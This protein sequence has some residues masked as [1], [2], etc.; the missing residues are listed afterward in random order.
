MLLAKRVNPLFSQALFMFSIALCACFSPAYGSADD[1][2]EISLDAAMLQYPDVGRDRIVFLFAND[3]WTVSRDGGLATPLASPAGR[4]LFP[5][6]STDCGTI[7]FVG[8]YDG[9]RDIYTIPATGGGM[10]TRVT[11]HPTGETLCDWTPSGDLLFYAGGI[12]GFGPKPK[13]FTVGT[14][15]GLPEK[16]PVPYGAA[17]SISPDGKWLAYTPGTR[18]SRTWKRYRGGMASD[19]WLFHLETHESVRVTD[20]EGTDSLPMWQGDK[21][22]YMSDRGEAHRLNI[23]V[24]DVKTGTHKQVTRFRDFDVKWPSIGPG[25]SGRGEIVLQNGPK[26]HLLDLRNHSLRDVKVRVPGARAAFREK[27]RDVSKSVRSWDISPTAKRALVQARG[28]IWTLPAEKGSPRNLTRTDGVAERLPSWSPDG[29]WIAYFSDATGEYE[30][31]ITRSDGKGETKQLTTES[32]TYYYGIIWSPDSER[33]ALID[34][35]ARL[36]MHTIETGETVVVDQDPWGD[37]SGVSWS[38]DSGWLAYSRSD[39]DH[40]TRTI[41]LYNVETGEHHKVTSGMFSDSA[42]TFD[43]KGEYLY[44]ASSRSFTPRYSD[45]DGTFI[46][47]RSEVLLAVPLKADT[48][49]PWL[50][51]SDEE[52]W[53]EEEDSTD[54]DGDSGKD[55]AEAET[56]DDNNGEKDGDSDSDGGNLD[57]GGDAASDPITGVWEG[58][59]QTPEGDLPF[60]IT[61]KLHDDNSVTGSMTSAIYTGEVTGSWN[62]SEKTLSLTLTLSNG[63]TVVMELE[64]SG[65]TL[66]GTG[67][68]DGEEIPITANRLTDGTE[69]EEEAGADETKKEEK[70]KKKVEIDIEGFES[71]AIKLPVPAGSYGALAVNDKN[72]LIYLRVGAGIRLFDVKDEKKTEKTIDATGRNFVVSSKGKKMLLVKGRG[73]SIRNAAAGGTGK[74]VVVSPMTAFIRP[75]NEWR[76]VFTDT[77]RLMRDFFYVDNMHGVDWKAV[78]TR[79][80][81]M[82]ETCNTRDDVTFVISEMIAEL[83][84][85][86]AYYYVGSEDRGP[87][88]SVGL[89]GVDWE[90]HE[91]A[92]RI[93]KI[94]SGAPWD[95]DARA[96]L[97]EAGIDVKEGD[98][99][100]AVNGVAV[101]TSKAPWAA[102]LG[103]SGKTITIRVSEKPV[104]DDEARDVVVKTISS[105]SRLRYRAWIEHNRSYVDKKSDGSVGYIYVPDTGVN[106]QTDLIRQFFGQTEKKA[107]IIDERW[108]GGG[109][110]PDRFIELLNR[111]ITNYWASRHGKESPTPRRGHHGPKCMLING[112]AGSGGDMFPWLFR[113]AGLGKLIGTRTWGGLVGMS[114]NPGL[115]DGSYVTVPTFGF[116]EKDG[117][118]AIEGHG[119]EPDI[120]V[121]DDPSLM[122]NGAD[123]QLDRA[124]EE[125]LGEIERNPAVRVRRPES[126]D[127]SGMGIEEADK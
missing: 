111:P 112:D 47:D 1:G 31:Y 79:Y 35:A 44:F 106:G 7:A 117:T 13:L 30:L 99:L 81:K 63:M 14:A 125:M 61:L 90:I 54:D 45:L 56:D 15:G 94:Y 10:P 108:N 97:N 71:R 51:E 127:R 115:I 26:L 80:G 72:Q 95:V 107:L 109:Q 36:L 123:P 42:P 32:R 28:D 83:N 88:V 93:A 2:E 62:S 67:E 23:W 91:G 102:F 48:K 11:H 38:H 68:G 22:Y 9:N 17:A 8:N 53:K 39:E 40:V 98:Y 122:L 21:I 64:V 70:E 41:R 78:H 29:K 25:P 57:P 34:M 27:Q 18:D 49:S 65:S 75:R 3:L 124:I 84:I 46:Y 77:W 86:H 103:L 96:P 113:E 66:A 74:K 12:T 76:Q 60:T 69:T 59:A 50:P 116:F 73:A 37:A 55:E 58:T 20:W 89:L 4:E 119:V 5:K 87:S 85:G 100:H 104:C 6:F 110:I 82:L 101:D 19:I 16:L 126:P 118:W 114:G 24:Y 120:E 121:I 92:Y 43:R 33:L 105:D 52:E